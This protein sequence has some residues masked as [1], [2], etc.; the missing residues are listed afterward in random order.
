MHI[1]YA[2]LLRPSLALV[3]GAF[4]SGASVSWADN[5]SP[6]AAA[7]TVPRIVEKD[8]RF[9][10]MVDGAPYLMLA[11]QANN[12]SN[13]PQVFPMVW[14]ANSDPHAHILVMSVAF[15]QLF[16]GER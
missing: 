4:L 9:A 3:F 8:G 11:G 2:L 13:Y 10:L 1:L 12:S 15:E 7:T 5:P 14:P 6:S 16:A